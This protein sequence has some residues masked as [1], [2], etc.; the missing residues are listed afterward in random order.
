MHTKGAFVSGCGARVHGGYEI[1][2]E[3]VGKQDSE[4]KDELRSWL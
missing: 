1:S 4:Q 3:L 2:L